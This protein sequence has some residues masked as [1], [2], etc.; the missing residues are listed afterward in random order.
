MH[1]KSGSYTQH[2]QKNRIKYINS[3]IPITGA[4]PHF[5]D[6]NCQCGN[7]LLPTQRN[8]NNTVA[9]NNTHAQ[10]SSSFKT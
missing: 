5:V 1:N 9:E 3:A 6:N 2:I 7:K 4:F 8:T 10:S